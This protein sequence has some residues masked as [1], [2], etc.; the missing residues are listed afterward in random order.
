MSDITATQWTV[1]PETAGKTLSGAMKASAADLSWRQIKRLIEVRRVTVNGRLCIDEVRRV[2]AD[3]QIVVVDH[4]LPKP[5][6]ADGLTI[7]HIDDAVVVVEK[8]PQVLS[9]RHR[10]EIHWPVE[11]R[12]MQPTLEEMLLQRLPR[13]HSES[14]P[15]QLPAKH[16]REMIRCVHRLDQDTSGL[17]VFARTEAAERSLITQFSAHTVERVYNAVVLGIP[18]IGPIVCNLVRDRGDGKRGSTSR[19]EDGKRA[20]TIVRSV[21]PVGEFSLVECELKT[22]RTHQIRIHLA[23]SGHP[24]CGDSLYRSAMGNDPLGDLS[25]APRLALHA[26]RLVFDHPAT[27]ERV[28]FE[29]DL[30]A[31]LGELVNQQ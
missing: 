22:G 10:A 18:K 30:P 29:A 31:D 28:E 1:S 11:R 12:L 5:A 15:I 14:D 17:L 27:E 26:Q 21:K 3:D 20:E 4:P 9:E 16:R 24:V 19:S 8:P 25:N 6:T 23:E 13:H 2:I 7:R